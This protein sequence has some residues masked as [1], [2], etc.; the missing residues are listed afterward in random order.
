CQCSP[1][2]VQ[3]MHAG[4]FPCAPLLLSLAVDL[5]VLEFTMNL[6][7]QIAPNNTAFSLALECV[8]S[9]M[10]FQL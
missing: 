1:A 5:C 7:I 6:F 2:A 9:N 3:L 4:T 8:L 10:G